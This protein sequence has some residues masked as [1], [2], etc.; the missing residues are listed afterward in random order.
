MALVAMPLGPMLYFSLR[1]PFNVRRYRLTNRRVGLMQGMIPQFT[2]FVDLDRFDTIEISV[3][4]GQAWYH[5]GDLIFRR[6]EIE[7]F[8]LPGVSRPG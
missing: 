7:T 6:G 3:L 5:A 8:R 2:R 1:A 4:P